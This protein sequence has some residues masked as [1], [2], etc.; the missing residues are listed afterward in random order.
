MARSPHRDDPNG[1]FPFRPH[2]RAET[3]VKLTDAQPPHLGAAPGRS[4]IKRAAVKQ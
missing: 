3:P 4:G 1:I 2:N